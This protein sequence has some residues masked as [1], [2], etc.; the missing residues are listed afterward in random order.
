MNP[1]LV[2]ILAALCGFALAVAGIYVLFGLGWS[3]MAGAGSFLLIAGFVRK[4]LT[5]G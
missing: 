1:L 2:Y 5:D 3:L 4:G